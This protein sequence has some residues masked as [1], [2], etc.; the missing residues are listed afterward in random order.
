MSKIDYTKAVYF[1]D[2][3]SFDDNFPYAVRIVDENDTEI[4]MPV[5][6]NKAEAIMFIDKYNSQKS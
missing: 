5:F 1:E 6:P 4:D 2:Y 3:I